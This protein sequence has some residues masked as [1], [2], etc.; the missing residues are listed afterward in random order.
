MPWVRGL[1]LRRKNIM[2]NLLFLGC[3]WEAVRPTLGP[4]V[5]IHSGQFSLAINVG[6][7]TELDKKNS[8]WH[9]I[10][11]FYNKLKQN[12]V[13]QLVELRCT[14]CIC[15]SIW[16]LFVLCFT[17]CDKTHV[18]LWFPMQSIIK[19]ILHA[20]YYESICIFIIFNSICNLVYQ[21]KLGQDAINKTTLIQNLKNK[22]WVT[23]EQKLWDIDNK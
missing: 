20:C 15:A 3:L 8:A 7:G 12:K 14:S 19:N 11:E 4:S 23:Y 5:N 9:Q 1:L 2:Y 16:R 6:E 22:Q 17:P 18:L 10:K 13:W 21:L